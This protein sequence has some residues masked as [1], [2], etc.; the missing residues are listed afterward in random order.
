MAMGILVSYLM[1]GTR[2]GEEYSTGLRRFLLSVD[3]FFFSHTFKG[4]SSIFQFF[5]ENEVYHGRGKD[6]QSPFYSA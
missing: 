1:N 5:K 3:I 2:N 4:K 6:E